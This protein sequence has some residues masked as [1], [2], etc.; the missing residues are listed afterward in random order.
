MMSI[1]QIREDFPIL[2]QQVN[3]KPLVYLDN[4]ATTQKP[5][6]VIQAIEHYYRETNA[7]VHRGVHAL[8]D[9]ATD[10][11]EGA[12]DRVKGFLNAHKREEIIWTRGTTESI[13]LVAQSYARPL[14]KPGDA[15]LISAMEHH[16]NIVPW[17]QVCEQTGATLKVIPVSA[18]GEL[19]MEAFHGLLNEGV[20]LVAVGH[21]S[22]A[23]GTINP[24]EAIVEH[25]HKVG[26][27]VLIDGAQGVTH[28][29]VDVQALDCDFYAFSAHKC[30]AGTGL[31]V[32]YGKE[33]LLERMPPYQVGGEMIEVVSFEG[34]TYNSLPY[35]FEA[36]TPHIAGAISLG[37]AIDYLSS[38]D[39]SA[40]AAHE[41]SLLKLATERIKAI[42]G[43][44]LVGT[45]EKKTGVLSFLLKDTHPHDLGSLM[46]R[47]GV[48]VRTG[49]HCAL[50]IMKL[51]GIPGTVRASFSIYNNETDVER[52]VASIEKAKSM[53][54]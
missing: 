7:N 53:L 3:G 27:K 24:V 51:F 1:D 33:Q 16:A 54:L 52:L 13:N 20:K 6:T 37:A 11:F 19:V 31:G 21:V 34:T 45:A 29:G 47:Q 23:F 43:V 18:R 42:E 9:Q 46:D 30:F 5:Q 40:L 22:N 49:H 48:A 50:P 39:R 38:L 10:Q 44:E 15:V 2:H 12:R 35:K 17:Q 36:G 4:A 32:L 28:F 8:S 25:A 14:L 26:A 41:D